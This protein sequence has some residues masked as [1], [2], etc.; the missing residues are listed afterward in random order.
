MTKSEAL[1]D[2]TI[3]IDMATDLGYA[4]QGRRFDADWISAM[5]Q[6]TAAGDWD[7]IDAL[8]AED[9]AQIAR[10]TA[11]WTEAAIRIGAERGYRVTVIET[12]EHTRQTRTMLDE[13]DT[14]TVE[15]DIWRA[16]HE[17]TSL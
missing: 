12:G 14:S 13:D 15:Q 3:T 6:A 10:L 17:A 9:N 5:D 16:A 2:I 11:E 8:E 7:T 4:C 1:T